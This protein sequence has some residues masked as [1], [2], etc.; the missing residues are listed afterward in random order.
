MTC[1]KWLFW[2][3]QTFQAEVKE[4]ERLKEESKRMKK[5]ET[6]FKALLKEMN[7]DFEQSWEEIR[8]KLENEEEFQS[9]DSDSERQRVYKVGN[10]LKNVILGR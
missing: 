2:R 6:G 4:K 8:I 3:F 9:F 1:K 5:L 10:D 7:V